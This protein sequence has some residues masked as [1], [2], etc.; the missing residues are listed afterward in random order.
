MRPE[1]PSSTWHA[2]GESLSRE[3]VAV[4]LGFT[5]IAVAMAPR[6]S[7][8]LTALLCGGLWPAFIIGVRLRWLRRP[9]RAVLLMLAASAAA[10]GVLTVRS[11]FAA[12][13]R[14]SLWGAVG[15]HSGALTW[16]VALLVLVA[17]CYAFRPGDLGRSARS[18]AIA[19]AMLAVA[20]LVQRTGFFAAVRFSAEPSGIMENSGS[21]GQMLSVTFFAAIA[22]A[23]GSRQ[24][25]QKLAA[26][27][28]VAMVVAGLVV[29]HSIGAWVGVGVGGAVGIATFML[30][31]YATLSARIATAVLVTIMIVSISGLVWMLSDGIS[32]GLE[33]RLAAAS[34]DR[35]T[36]WTSAI[37]QVAQAPLL[38]SGAEQF[39]AWVNWGLDSQS[40][41]NKTATYDPH[42]LAL[43]WLV[44]AGLLGAVLALCAAGVILTL[45]FTALADRPVTPIAALV[46]APIAWI[47]A[48][49][50]VWT[51]PLALF[52]VALIVGQVGSTA[53]ADPER[54]PLD[55]SDSVGISAVAAVGIAVVLVV[56]LWG[57]PAEYRWARSIDRGVSDPISLVRLATQTGDPSLA[58][59]AF[60]AVLSAPTQDQQA[61]EGQLAVLMPVLQRASTW[62]VDSAFARFVFAMRGVV[63]K[64]ESSWNRASA[65]LSAGR[66]ADPGSGL[67][68]SVGAIQATELGFDEQA[69]GYARNASV[70]ALPADV[71]AALE[72]ILAK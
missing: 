28:C 19:G 70:H 32:P 23:L 30:A 2:V 35:F 39:S 44:S 7:A 22:W 15:Q 43:N 6:N 67:W 66:L 8:A 60:D 13:S 56:F 21:L 53:D 31:R 24:M 12:G 48:V 45:L 38:G 54:G 41:L 29:T 50:F 17:S 9:G 1:A 58:V 4:A 20:A 10:V 69:K 42:N 47:V 33:T 26:W 52:A 40:G 14:V 18:L 16:V 65:G 36:I 61:V 64:N 55:R 37:G 49:M 71:A 63:P 68:D 25:T 3:A 34:N 11:A 51:S 57:A 5:L 46:T 27:T 59:A 62:H 72:P